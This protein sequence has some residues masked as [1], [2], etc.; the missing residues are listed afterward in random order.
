VRVAY[1]D[2]GGDGP[3]LLLVHATG[4]CGAVL[5]PMAK[6]L[7][8]RFRCVLLDLRG[9]GLSDRPA[10][11]QFDWGGFASDILAVTDRMGLESPSGFGHSCGGAALLL[12]EQSRP[13]TFTGLFCYEPVIYP[14]EVP[15][16]PSRDGN[17]LSQ[18]ASRRRTEFSSREEA[19]ENFSEKA[20]FDKLRPDVLAAYV[21][22]GF[23]EDADGHVSL[24]C[25]REDEAEIYA[26]SFSHDAFARLESVGCPVSLACGAQT[27][28]FGPDFLALFADRL[29]SS[30]TLA[31]AGLGHFG[32]L[33]DPDL[34]AAAVGSSAAPGGIR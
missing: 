12:S 28:G 16:A 14:G 5:A 19:L 18:G 17:P 30:S 1:Y 10:D 2:L 31:L 4:F 7:Q 21:D 29:P 8:D 25:R 13:G 34:L 33:E 11:G 9:H 15:L 22:N 3:D 24:R 23:A 27:D 26:H 32:P 6:E 20:P